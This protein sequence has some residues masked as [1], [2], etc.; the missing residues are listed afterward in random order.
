MVRGGDNGKRI[1]REGKNGTRTGEEGEEET[2]GTMVRGH[3]RR[4]QW[5][6]DMRGED[7]GIRT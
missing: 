6:E 5:Y 7:I 3:K 2:E 1:L 4:G